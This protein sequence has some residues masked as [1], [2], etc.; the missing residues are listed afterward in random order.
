LYF[1]S[2]W[3]GG[4]VTWIEAQWPGNSAID[5]GTLSGGSI[6]LDGDGD[7]V[8]EVWDGKSVDECSDGDMRIE[9]YNNREEAEEAGHTI[10]GN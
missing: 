3:P 7:G 8:V 1:L 5:Y 6:V 10:P 9:V 2:P 4:A